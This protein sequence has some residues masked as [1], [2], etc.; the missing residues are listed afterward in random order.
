[1][2]GR[3]EVACRGRVVLKT[4]SASPASLGGGEGNDTIVRNVPVSQGYVISPATWTTKGGEEEG[5]VGDTPGE[6][7]DE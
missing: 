3:R 2:R 1:M 6:R 7:K 4:V 5:T